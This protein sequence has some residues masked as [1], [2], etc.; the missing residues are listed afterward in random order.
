[1]YILLLKNSEYSSY[2]LGRGVDLLERDSSMGQ[3]E[4]SRVIT[5]E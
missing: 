4:S 3:D 2:S 1:M 5:E